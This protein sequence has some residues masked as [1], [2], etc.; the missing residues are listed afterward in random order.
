M[1]E[2]KPMSK[3]ASSLGLRTVPD[4][5]PAFNKYLF[6][7]RMNWIHQEILYYEETL[8]KG[9]EEEAEGSKDEQSIFK[10]MDSG[11][12]Y[13]EQPY[14]STGWSYTDQ[15]SV[16][17]THFDNAKHTMQCLAPELVLN[18]YV[19]KINYAITMTLQS[20]RLVI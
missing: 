15:Q 12:R 2:L 4:T 11:V 7:E 5:W 18:K 1:T 8:E 16:S 10:M 3:W 6:N 20:L 14:H 17:V 9:R 13:K 19:L